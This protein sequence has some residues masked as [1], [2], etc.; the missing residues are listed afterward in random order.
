LRIR[1][2]VAKQQWSNI[3]HLITS[4]KLM[5]YSNCVCSTPDNQMEPDAEWSLWGK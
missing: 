1:H 4:Q 2:V 3:P 5:Y